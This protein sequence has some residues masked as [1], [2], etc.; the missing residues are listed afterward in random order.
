VDVNQEGCTLACRS[1]H[2]TIRD[3]C[4]CTLELQQGVQLSVSKAFS[5]EP[6]GNLQHG[7]CCG[8]RHSLYDYMFTKPPPAKAA[9]L[10]PGHGH[11]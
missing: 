6:S 9:I 11:H 7:S 8:T 1:R 4:A 2:A 10:Q 3:G 5:S